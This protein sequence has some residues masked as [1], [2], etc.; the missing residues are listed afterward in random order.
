MVEMKEAN[1]AISNA[2]EKSLILFDEL[3]RGTA[4]YDGMSLAESIL[5]Y[6]HNHVKCKTLF[7]THYHELTKM[8]KTLKRI[9]NI[10]VSAQEEDGNITFLHKVKDGAIDKSY[11][12]NVAMLANL[13][14]EVID[15]ANEILSFYENKNVNKKS[16]VMQTSF[17]FS[18]ESKH[19]E[20]LGEI[21]E[22]NPL[23]L[24]PMEAINKL[25]EIVEKVK[26]E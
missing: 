3:G 5:E 19:E 22:I 18:N 1:H 7:S 15:R 4:T 13:P 20:I 6:I 10:H 26:K 17:D 12:I 25:Y 11:G 24:T 9:K 16:N 8:T 2:T 21:K 23:E 14:K